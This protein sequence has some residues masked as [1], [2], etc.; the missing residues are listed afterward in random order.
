M[1]LLISIDAQMNWSPNA[2]CK[3]SGMTQAQLQQLV[4]EQIMLIEETE[5]RR[6][7][8]AGRHLDFA[9]TPLT[10]TDAQQYALDCI[11]GA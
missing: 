11:V 3:A 6:D 8:L 9:T 2:L 5:I 4:R 7:P 1:P 10:L